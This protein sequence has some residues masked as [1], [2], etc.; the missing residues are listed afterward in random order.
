MA[1]KPREQR[2]GKRRGQILKEEA[3][4]PSL[5]E[6]P[7]FFVP[8]KSTSSEELRQGIGRI[9]QGRLQERMASMVLEGP[10]L[11]KLWRLLKQ[12][13]SPPHV[14]GQ[15]CINY[16]DFSQVADAFTPTSERA[17]EAF[18]QASRS[19]AGGL[20]HGNTCEAGRGCWT[21]WGCMYPPEAWLRL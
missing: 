10:Q 16:D 14:Q 15:D 8:K 6:I 18:F 4:E 2:K 1:G 19:V 13:A 5:T 3:Q 12:H 20:E 11:D 17:H 9:V 7:R 21:C